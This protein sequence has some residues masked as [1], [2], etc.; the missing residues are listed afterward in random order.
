[1]PDFKLEMKL[2][3]CIYKNSSRKID[4][5]GT[6]E[7][8][9]KITKED[10]YKCYRNFYVPNNMFLLIVGNFNPE[11]AVEVIKNELEYRSKETLP[12]VIEQEE[13]TSVNR[14]ILSIKEN[15]EVPKVAMGIKISTSDLKL[16]S[17]E[18]DLYLNM[19]TTILFGSSSEFR[20]R[21]RI[22]KLLNSIYLEWETIPNYKVFYIM[23]TSLH[24]EKLIEEINDEWNNLSISKSSFDRIKKVWI[25][26]EVKMI[27]NLD[28]TANNLYDDILKYKKIIPNK[29]EMIRNMKI[30]KLNQ[31]L[32]KIDWTNR[33]IVKM[34]KMEE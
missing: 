10:L 14:K 3:D 23:A 20:E 15:I 13:P 16:H 2:R 19:I 21:V 11:E 33:S 17:I 12:T 22:K 1:M 24:P 32:K 27:D 8:I 30:E 29:I 5:A 31:L 25:A 18:I 6:I 26:N 28:A 7:E 9:N 34:R 4:I